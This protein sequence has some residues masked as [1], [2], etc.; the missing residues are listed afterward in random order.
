MGRVLDS[1]GYAGGGKEL[2]DM[3]VIL[4][5]NLPGQKARIKL[6]LALGQTNDY[7]LI[8]DIFEKN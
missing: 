5:N 3:G 4:G 7:K 8:K 1:Y 6:M 2:R